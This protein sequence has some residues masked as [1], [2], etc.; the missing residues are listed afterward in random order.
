MMIIKLIKMVE[1]TKNVAD[2]NKNKEIQGHEVKRDK[3]NIA[4]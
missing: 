1:L 4:Y 2:E 3:Y